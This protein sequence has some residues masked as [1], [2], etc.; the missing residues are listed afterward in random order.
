MLIIIVLNQLKDELM[1]MPKW[2]II[3]L[4]GLMFLGGATYLLYRRQ[5]HEE[6]RDK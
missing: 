2:V 3:G 6:G 5:G 4:I 1:A